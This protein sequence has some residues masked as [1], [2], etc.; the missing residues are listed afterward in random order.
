MTIT[1]ILALIGF[2]L[3]DNNVKKITAKDVRDSFKLLGDEVDDKIDK[4]GGNLNSGQISSLQ[5]VLG[6][7]S[8]SGGSGI[9][10]VIAGDNVS[11]NKT[12]PK[13]PVISATAA[14]I[15]FINQAEA[16]STTAPS[17]E[18][19]KVVSN[20]SLWKW[21]QKAIQYLYFTTYNS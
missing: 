6:I 3:P 15:N 5:N 19:N 4:D 1:E 2:K 16:E 12:N 20:W 21:W 8:G 18:T 14:P 7:N 9:E 13:K 17:A 11:I 10:D